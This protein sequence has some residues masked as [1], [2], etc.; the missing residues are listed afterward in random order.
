[1]TIDVV[2]SGAAGRLGRRILAAVAGTPGLTV[3]AGLEREGAP[4]ATLAELAGVAGLAGATSTSL[5]AVAGRGRVLIETGPRPVA[6]AHARAAAAAGMPVLVC[7]TGLD[8]AERAELAALGQRVP[9]VVAANLSLGV[10]VLTD[11]VRRASAALPGYALEI[12]EIHHDKKRDAPSGTAWALGRAA[13]EARG[14]DVE[15]DAILARAGDVGPRSEGEIGLMALRGGDVVGE[16]TVY[17]FGPAE[18]LELTHRASSRDVFAHGAAR[19][20]LYLGAAE[21]TPGL[22]TMADVLGLGGS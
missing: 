17:L 16:H 8:P 5:E 4:S 19:A 18:R 6:L 3:A 12:V 7:T 1:M 14:R 9:L 11:L 21:R 10:A 13:A 2:V 22:Y 15:R 20:A